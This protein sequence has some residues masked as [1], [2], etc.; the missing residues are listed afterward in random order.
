L[1]YGK[2][3]FVVTVFEKYTWHM[4]REYDDIKMEFKETGCNY[5]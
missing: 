2:Q 5:W 4:S 3:Y 1:K